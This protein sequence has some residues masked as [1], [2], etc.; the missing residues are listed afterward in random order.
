[1]EWLIYLL[2]VSACLALFY[3]FYY[4]FLQRL[5]F[6]NGNR[7]YL[8]STLII[9][10][11]IPSL[12]LELKG[13]GDDPLL[14]KEES[15]FYRDSSVEGKV[16]VF[17]A[18]AVPI[19]LGELAVPW[20]KRVVQGDWIIAACTFGMFLFQLARLLWYTRHIDEEIGS[21]K[22]IY[23]NKGFTNCSFFNYVFINKQALTSEEITQIIR[24]ERVHVSCFHSADKIITGL[25]KSLLWFNPLVYL[26]DDSLEQ[27]HEFE[28]DK[29]S[30][31][32]VGNI[33]Y[34]SFLL[35]I[36]VKS[37]SVLVHSFAKKPL[38]KR[39]KMLFNTQSRNITKLSYFA[40]LPLG[41]LLAWTFGVQFIYANPMETV[42]EKLESAVQITPMMLIPA[43]SKKDASAAQINV[44]QFPS[45]TLRMI[46]YT[47]LGANPKVIIDGK[48][49]GTDILYRISPRCVITQRSY[50]GKLVLTTHDHKIEYATEIDRQNQRIRN[51]ARAVDKFYVRYTLKNQDGSM[52]DEV[53]I[54]TDRRGSG[55]MVSLK[56]GSKLLF[57]IEGKQYPEN[58]MSSIGLEDYKDWNLSLSS[59]TR[60]VGKLASKF[61]TEYNAMVTLVRRNDDRIT[62]P[63]NGKVATVKDLKDQVSYVAKDSVVFDEDKQA[64]TLYGVGSTIN[65]D[66][67]TITADQI[68]YFGKERR[69][70]AKKSASVFNSR[71]HAQSGISDS[72]QFDLKSMI[73]K[74]FGIR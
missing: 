18:D 51:K 67:Y 62:A 6:F 46:D 40:A 49:Y 54:K 3:A 2:K 34:A 36:A 11:L 57:L 8:M 41:F 65:F 63:S 33:S 70:V 30:S 58:L 17:R 26:Y 53:Q 19:E 55:G 66:A 24:H 45:D 60:L 14:V 71:Q 35:A 12:K 5:T 61:G 47:G 22:L 10:L 48:S 37:N 42:A 69:G 29:Q 44:R 56:K 15:S 7:I 50:D 28:A 32:A 9:S 64:I 27:V 21:L 52:Y 43:K 23:K 4:I 73:I 38:K 13:A 72:V 74:S 31:K 59:G 39:I 68:V 1:M 16:E 20:Q 25:F